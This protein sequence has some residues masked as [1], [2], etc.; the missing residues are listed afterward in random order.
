MEVFVE[1]VKSLN[2]CPNRCSSVSAPL[3]GGHS[4]VLLLYMPA[5]SMKMN[6]GLLEDSSSE[7]VT[8]VVVVI[9]VTYWD[10]LREFEMYMLDSFQGVEVGN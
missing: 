7:R 5:S 3:L 4:T 9:V 1:G 8:C 6:D 10:W 2:L